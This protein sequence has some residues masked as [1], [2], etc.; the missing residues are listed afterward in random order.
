MNSEDAALIRRGFQLGDV[1]VRF[2]PWDKPDGDNPAPEDVE[3]DARG[4]VDYQADKC[5]FLIYFQEE[6]KE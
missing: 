1:N 3:K 6:G 2:M 5:M 4:Q